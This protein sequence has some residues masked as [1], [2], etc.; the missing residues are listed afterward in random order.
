MGGNAEDRIDV[1]GEHLELGIA[2]QIAPMIS[3]EKREI[4]ASVGVEVRIVS[5]GLGLS[6]RL[7]TELPN[8][9]SRKTNTAR[10]PGPRALRRLNDGRRKAAPVLD[11]A[12][13]HAEIQSAQIRGDLLSSSFDA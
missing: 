8:D 6:T 1:H 13:E 12:P 3:G 4:A 7:R 5:F 2:S 9:I 11:L 10:N